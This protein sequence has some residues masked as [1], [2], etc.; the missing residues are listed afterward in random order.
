M[1]TTVI[2]K[3]LDLG[4]SYLGGLPKLYARN[5]IRGGDWANVCHISGLCAGEIKDTSKVLV[6]MNKDFDSASN[7]EQVKNFLKSINTNIEFANDYASGSFLN[8]KD[9]LKEANKNHKL[10]NFEKDIILENKATLHRIYVSAIA[11]NKQIELP[12]EFNYECQSG[13]LYPFHQVYQAICRLL[14]DK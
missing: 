8:P 5:V 6:I 7:L 10:M 3:K 4:M 1:N 12:A 2:N 11:N 13:S 14:A 9:V